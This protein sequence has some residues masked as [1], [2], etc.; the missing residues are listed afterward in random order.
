VSRILLTGA[1]GL[2]GAHLADSLG[3][4]QEIFALGRSWPAGLADG[5]R[6]I[7]TDLASSWTMDILPAK[8]DAVIHLAQSN[9]WREF[10]QHAADI[11]AVNVATTARLL[12]YA[13]RAGATQFV[14]ASTGGLYGSSDIAVTEDSVLK[15]HDGPLRFYFESKRAA[16]MLA[17]AYSDRLRVSILRPFFIYGP[18][19]RSPKLVPR[20][21]DSVRRGTPVLLRGEFGTILNPVAVE[22]VTK[23]IE[24]CLRDGYHGLINVSGGQVTSIRSMADRIAALLGVTASFRQESGA[25]EQFV[26]DTTLMGQLLGVQPIGFDDGIAH[27]LHRQ[28]VP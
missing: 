23:L 28:E 14:L 20:L 7:V 21:V 6:P 12:D 25:A 5:V 16:E 22:D 26:A 24:A 10:P 9:R 1:S 15:A 4:S 17:L 19:Q 3:R 27:L 11:F 2:I 18:G 13:V 8:I